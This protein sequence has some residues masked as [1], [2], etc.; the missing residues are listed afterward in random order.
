MC[1][2]G[3]EEYALENKIPLINVFH[4]AMMSGDACTLLLSG[5][6][7]YLP[8]RLLLPEIEIANE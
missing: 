4:A 3:V 5:W 2:A 6:S 8:H 7:K 1:R